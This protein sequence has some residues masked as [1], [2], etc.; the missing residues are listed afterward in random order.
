M[1][2]TLPMSIV[3]AAALAAGGCASGAWKA[4]GSSVVTEPALQLPAH[5]AVERVT[6]RIHGHELEF[7]GYRTVGPG[8]RDV[9]AQ[10]LLESGISAL[11]VSV[12]GSEGRRISGSAFEAIPNFA[13]TA[14]D[15]LRRTWGGR[16]IFGSSGSAFASGG[17]LAREVVL[18]RNADRTLPAEI[19][20]DGSLLALE[21]RAD[22]AKDPLR[23]TVLD[24]DL[25]P[26]ATITYSDFDGDG[27]P[28]EIHLVDLRRK[29]TLDV[30]VEEVTLV[31]A[32]P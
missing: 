6:M 29:H 15:D 19:V 12:H 9:R 14:M 5:R 22:P 26:E 28:R 20:D 3:V 10:L 27:I 18:V 30:E 25:V 2:R 11:D 21:P 32:K 16:S 23:V 1:A 8:A 24:R 4:A 7:V 13:E 17:N 31:G